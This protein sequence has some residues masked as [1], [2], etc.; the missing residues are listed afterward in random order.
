MNEDHILKKF[1]KIDQKLEQHD[2]QFLG[3]NKKL[4]EHDRRF[5]KMDQQFGEI[6][7]QLTFHD[8][9]FVFIHENMITQDQFTTEIRKLRDDIQTGFDQVVTMLKRLDEERIFMIARLDRLENRN[10]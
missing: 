4:E 6:R 1:E 5:D 8:E 3:I 7:E 2:V 9:Q 10:V